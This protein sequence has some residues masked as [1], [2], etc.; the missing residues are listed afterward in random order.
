MF[1]FLVKLYVWFRGR[2]P[3]DNLQILVTSIV[4]HSLWDIYMVNFLKEQPII[5]EEQLKTYVNPLCIQY[6]T[7]WL[8]VGARISV[9]LSHHSQIQC[10]Y[11]ISKLYN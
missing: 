5:I 6:L 2:I 8:S 9:P 4:T 1:F 7:K 10:R 11:V 3:I